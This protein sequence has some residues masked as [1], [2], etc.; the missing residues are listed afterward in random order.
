MMNIDTK[1]TFVANL[2]LM[3]LALIADALVG[4]VPDFQELEAAELA[5]DMLYQADGGTAAYV[6]ALEPNQIRV[7]NRLLELRRAD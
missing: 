7:D 2:S 6:Q 5:E 1:V 4:K 3:E